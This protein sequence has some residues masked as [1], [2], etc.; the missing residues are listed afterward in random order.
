MAAFSEEQKQMVKESWSIPKQNPI[1]SGEAI[2]I[3]FLEKYPHNKAK[4]AAFRDIPLLSLKVSRERGWHDQRRFKSIDSSIS[5]QGN[6]GVRT[7]AAR[8]MKVFQAAVDSLDSSDPE[9][10]LQR[11]W[12]KVAVTHSHHL[13]Q[14]DSFDELR[15]VVLEVLT[16]AC[17]LDEEQQVAWGVLFDVAYAIVFHKLDEIY[18]R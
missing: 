14:K 10:H 17:S 5:L 15:D 11:V 9:G 1:D 13:I 4:F 8:I 6:P 12:T 16:S 18:E 2:F 3:R 7:H